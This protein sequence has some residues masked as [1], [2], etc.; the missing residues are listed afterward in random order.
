MPETPDIPLDLPERIVI[1]PT[2]TSVIFALAL[3]GATCAT[4]D[5]IRTTKRVRL[6]RKLKQEK[7]ANEPTPPTE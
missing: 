5:V 2:G 4:M 3:Y 7:K 1:S 6:C